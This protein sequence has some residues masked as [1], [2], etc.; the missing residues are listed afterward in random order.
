MAS[1]EQVART[2]E[3]SV[4]TVSRALRGRAGVSES[5]RQRVL[6]VAEEL[7]YTISRSASG[8][9]TGRTHC[10]GV[11]VP[12]VGRW[13]YGQVIG[14][15]E[16]ALRRTGYDVM[17]YAVGDM[18]ARKR[19][20]HELPLRRGV[21]AVLVVAMPLAEHEAEA[22]RSLEVPLAAVGEQ[23]DGFG[24]VSIDDR[25]GARRAVEHL[26]EL[27]HR[28]I[29][30]ISENI[31][32]MGFTPSRDRYAGYL[33]VLAE[34]GI[35]PRDDLVTDGGYTVAGGKR[36]MSRL[37]AA[38][39][40]PTAVFAHSDEMAMGA[41]RALSDRGVS[42]PGEMSV[43]GFDG[44]EM[45]EVVDLTTVVQPVGE[46]GAG[47]ARMLLDQLQSGGDPTGPR[48]VV[49]PTE[50]VARGTTGA[51]RAGV[52]QTRS[53]RQPGGET[54]EVMPGTAPA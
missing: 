9:V 24:S 34:H 31:G 20:F 39:T 35:P 17:L 44:H 13:F 14:A 32:P 7:H 40:P 11:V 1:I 3:V 49:L 12:Y 46:E 26:V 51:P 42:V 21:D 43:V 4:A 2:A 19:F 33:D 54:G 16:E 23:P 8:L 52:P 28:E 27:G 45:G 29:G 36:G 50:L 6:A 18:E 53:T 22:L 30:L 37:L 15:A 25:L 10:V 47:A 41:L 38:N 5:T 48:D